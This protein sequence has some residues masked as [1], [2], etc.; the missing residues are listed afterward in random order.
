MYIM[1]YNYIHQAFHFERRRN[2]ELP[3]SIAILFA[4]LSIII[5]FQ[6]IFILEQPKKRYITTG[7]VGL[8]PLHVEGFDCFT[9]LAFLLSGMGCLL[10]SHYD[11]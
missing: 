6:L 9:Y 10:M 8:G 5:I 2:N 4:L 1:L 7:S 3:V 11:P